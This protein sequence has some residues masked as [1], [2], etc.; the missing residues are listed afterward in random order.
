MK[1]HSLLRAGL[2]F[3]L[4]LVSAC[5]SQQ[6][7]TSQ[8]AVNRTDEAAA[9]QAL[10]NIYRQETQYSLTHA[11]EYG[12]FDDLV[13]E[14]FLDERFKGRSPELAGYIFTIRLRPQSGS[15]SAA[16]AVNADPKEAQGG[17]SVS[18]A[19]HLYLD[20]ISN[21]V[22]ANARQPATE[23]DPPLQ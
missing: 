23:S 10:R 8:K 19:R 17:S 3:S 12:S 18:G 9:V 6:V 5:A 21:V 2:V 7:E 16:F 14:N 15:D 22:R 20:S 13:K 4:L 11:G 1:N